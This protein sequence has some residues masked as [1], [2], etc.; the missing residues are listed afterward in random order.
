VMRHEARTAPEHSGNDHPD[1]RYL[2]DKQFGRVATVELED[3]EGYTEA[4][5]VTRFQYDSAGNQLTSFQRSSEGNFAPSNTVDTRSF[6]GAD[7]RL[8]AYQKYD[9]RPAPSQSTTNGLFED[10]RYDPLGRRV[11]VRT[12]RPPELCN[13]P[14]SCYNSITY[15]VWAG[16]Q[17]LWELRETDPGAPQETRGQVSYFQAGGIDRPLTI[18]KQ[19][20]GTIVTHQSW[21]GQF[22]RGTFGV[23]AR[24]GESSDCE[25][26]PPTNGCLPVRWPGWNTSAWSQEAAK[27][28]T[29]GSEE[30]WFGS[31][32]VGMRDASGQ[33]YMR[34]RYYNPQTGQFTQPDPIGL[35][36]GLNSYGFA[37]G[38]PV[39]YADPYGLCPC[40]GAMRLGRVAVGIS[41]VNPAPGPE[42]VVA[43]SLLAVAGGVWLY[44]EFSEG[45]SEARR[46]GEQIDHANSLFAPAV[47]HI[48]LMQGLG[49]DDE[50]PEGK[51]SIW[52]KHAKKAI[53][54]TRRAVQKLR[55]EARDTWDETL[56]Q[57]EQAIT[58]LLERKF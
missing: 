52:A 37:A 1:F 21:R 22:A 18:W 24:A 9:D 6:Y 38:D 25:E 14:S 13:Q 53:N 17:L 10:Y 11:A 7:D 3:V 44:S 23:G 46:R 20:I 26:Y 54:N 55:G 50:D 28:G 57:A 56:R 27:P 34:N 51:N 45:I 58:R 48:T 29:T 49:P 36:G 2:L 4:F 31:L 40:A 39:S 41:L 8:R 19:D 30:F 5:D 33:Q 16:D 32:S 12:R 35:A 43:L 15:F 47:A 42:D